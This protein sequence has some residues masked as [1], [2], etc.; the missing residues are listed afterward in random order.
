MTDYNHNQPYFKCP[1]CGCNCMSRV[2]GPTGPQGIPGP[3]GATG[4]TGPQGVQGSDGQQGPQGPTGPTGPTPELPL[5][6]DSVLTEIQAF[7][8][9]YITAV[10][11]STNS[12]LQ[13]TG[14][15][16]QPVENFTVDK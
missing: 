1:L 2:S 7:N 15:L 13:L 6:Y 12:Q 5:S 9:F 10:Y 8:G 4:P 3:Q 14:A 11:D 16:A